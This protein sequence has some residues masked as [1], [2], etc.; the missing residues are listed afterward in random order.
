[1]TLETVNIKSAK[2]LACKEINKQKKKNLK[3]KYKMKLHKMGAKQPF[4]LLH[5][6]QNPDGCWQ[7]CRLPDYSGSD[8]ST[9][10]DA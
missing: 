5:I 2:C 8:F 1:M 10:E 3:V 6:L 9:E 4:L 7:W